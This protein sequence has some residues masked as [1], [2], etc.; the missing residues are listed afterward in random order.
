MLNR[1]LET[2]LR[3]RVL[4]ALG[5]V[6]VA[7]G[8]AAALGDLRVDAFPDTTPV[9]VQ[10]NTVA[11]ALN[12]EEVELQIS[13]PVEA[14]IS[15][16]PGLI[17]VRSVSKFGFSQIVATFDDHTPV[18]DARQ[19][20]AERLD[21][22]ELASGIARPAL[23]PIATGLGEIF[24]YILSSPDGSHDLTE[25]RTLHDWVVKPELRRVPGIAEINSWGG[26]E[27]VYEV[28]VDPPALLS[29]GLTLGDVVSALERNNRNV[30]GGVVTRAG[31]GLLVHG[32]GR[33]TGAEDIERAVITSHDGVP[34]RVG[35][36]AATLVGREIR[37]G[38]VTADGKGEVVLGLGFM[39]MGEN[40]KEIT[41]RLSRRIEELRPSLPA[42]VELDVVYTRT[43]LVDR[44]IET[45][46]HNLLLGGILV[47]AILFLLLG[48]VRAGIIIA[49]TIP[50]SFLM[51]VLGMREL[52][53]AASLLSLGAMDFGIIV[54]GSVVAAENI[55]RR[56]GERG[57]VS[58]RERLAVVLDA[59][60]E[61]V[62][63]VFFGVA[64]IALVLL[65]VLTLH[66]PE[67]KLFRPMAL[68]LM[69]ALGGA[70]VISLT[71]TPALAYWWLPRTE[72][73]GENAVTRLLERAYGAVLARALR[74]RRAVLAGSCILIVV[75]GAAATRLGSEFM[76]RLSEGAIVLNIVRL[77]GISIEE[78]A[79]YNTRMERMIREAFPD[80]VAHVWSRI[81]TAEVATDPMGTELTDVFLALEPR[82][83]WTRA[84]SQDDLVGRIQEVV[85]DLPGQT[86]AYTQPIEMRVSEMAAGIRSALGIKVYGE[87][88]AT[89]DRIAVDLERLVGSVSGASD[90]SREQLTG[91]PVLRLRVDPTATAQTGV[92]TDEVL[93]VVAA[94]G[95]VPAGDVLEGQRQFPILVRLPER[96]RRDPAA[97]ADM[98]VPTS[99]GAVLPL[100]TV[101]TVTLEEAPATITREW[102]RRRALVQSNVRGRDV[103]SFV[104]EVRDRVRTE[105][106]LPP[107][108]TVDY[109]GQFEQME[110]ANR[111]FAILVPVVLLVV[112]VLLVVGMQRVSDALI[113]F[114][115]VPLAAIGGIL[116]LW[117]RGLPFSVSA[118]VGFIALS[119]IAVLNGQVLV[120]TMRRLLGGGRPVLEAIREAARL[121]MRPVLATAVTDVA[122]FLPM[123]LS[124]GVGAEVQ[125]PLATVV[126]GGIVTSTALTLIVLPVVFAA[127]RGA[128]AGQ[129]RR[130]THPADAP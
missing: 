125:R 18:L 42:G 24:H 22:V 7:V 80:E 73:G 85:S 104:R 114:T 56:L 65:P 63:P 2:A 68:T 53:I 97:L 45:V 17:D 62:R 3:Y 70:L 39:L 119:G 102:S 59:S 120:A 44:V 58:P 64:I 61:V 10:L 82:A 87:D 81:G 108:Y 1:L 52:G 12:P 101:A 40:A 13:F 20:V 15:G 54:D 124:A 33:I 57:V 92:S 94:V 121:R 6:L 91:Q 122:G 109:G 98:L 43:E 19:L 93:Q 84:R 51:A 4:V 60:R 74:F 126:I 47:V 105:I 31:E 41:E 123:A 128:R 90:V 49:L 8:G 46:T 75:A 103:G 96:M 79:A 107:G 71:L 111:R 66:G 76:P 67:G 35:D 30:G 69:F 29:Y 89:L 16:I 14:A 38:A 50:L 129:A 23:G 127:R 9:Q 86:V 36:V 117:V 112:F 78:S 27:K 37:R 11:P 106:D 118:A 130:A 110:R 26:N 5:F 25:L 28:A 115:G 99:T 32:V 48:S 100:Q 55:Q 83:G 77:A 113:V 116:A 21:A 72:T 34:V 88:F 95:G